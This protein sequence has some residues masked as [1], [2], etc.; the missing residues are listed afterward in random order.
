MQICHLQ[1]LTAESRRGCRK[2]VLL[3]RPGSITAACA[4]R[5]TLD[6]LLPLLPQDTHTR[7][8]KPRPEPSTHQKVTLWLIWILCSN[9]LRKLKWTL[10]FPEASACALLPVP[11]ADLGCHLWICRLTLSSQRRASTPTHPNSTPSTHP[12]VVQ[13]VLV[14]RC[15]VIKVAEHRPIWAER[16]QSKAAV[17]RLEQ[18]TRSI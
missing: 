12:V 8:I 11:R 18:V 16:K 6:T 14:S 7:Q 4:A 5:Y 10:L 3:I 15:H 17:P 1:C 2:P 9:H 13:R